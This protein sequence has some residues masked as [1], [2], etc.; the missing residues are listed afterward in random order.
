MSVKVAKTAGFCYGVRRAVDEV[1]K[2]VE[3]GEKIGVLGELIHNQ[4]VIDDLKSR[5]VKIYDDILDA[6]EDRTLIIRTHGVKKEVIDALCKK[7]ITIVDLTCPFV[8]KIHKIVKEN[9]ENGAQIVI[10][11]DKNHPEVIG[12]NGWCDDTAFITYDESCDFTP[13][14]DKNT[15]CVVAQTTINKEIFSKI[16]QNIKNTCKSVVVFDTICN[17]TK[18]RQT[19]A[20]SLS[21][22]SDV[23]F[24]I[25]G[26]KSSNTA[27]LFDIAK[28]NCPQAYFI[29]TKSD[30][31]SGLELKNKK[32]GIT[33]GAS[34]PGRIIE[35]VL[36][37]MDEK[38]T[39]EESFAE[40]FAQS[41]SKTLNNGDIVDAT[42]VE[43]RNNEVIV[44]LGG[45]KYNGQLAADQ[46]SDDPYA[47][48]TDL[49]KPGDVIK[50]YV[51]GVNDA[52]G[53][54][55]LSRKKLVAMESWNKMK[56]AFENKEI[57]NGKIIRS[58]KGGVIALVNQTQVFVPARHAALRFVQDLDSLVNTEVRLRLI[59]MDERKKRFVGSVRSV[60]EEEKKAVEDAFWASAEVGK[61]YTGAV[62]SLTSFGAF[63]DLGGVDG[64]VHISELSWNKIKH[65]SEVVKE[66]DV[67]T[68]YIKDL[69]PE[70]KK[71]SLGYKKAEDNP[72]V[73]AKSKYNV[74]DVVKCKVVRIMPFGA[75]CELMPNV[76]GLI[77]ISQIAD[78]RIGKPEDVLTIGDEV[79]AKILAIDWDTNKIS[80]SI[81]A[82]IEPP[83]EEA[84][85]EAADAP[86]EVQ[87]APVD[88]EVPVDIE[89]YIAENPAEE[90]EPVAE[91]AEENKDSAQAEE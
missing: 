44:D 6:E 38:M 78:R 63:V 8:G 45:F 4:Y 43:I 28:A 85:S 74:G 55:V 84:K 88:E 36:T 14:S 17:A 71:I 21:A 48:V 16:V 25:G 52:E 26:R 49:V 67:V 86:E 12:I 77:H 72:W 37:T 22:Q 10:I 53:K 50:V 24:V 47:K 41:E 56:E 60:L 90:E 76:D 34:T 30:I 19:E 61:E 33:A 9:Y 79:E 3:S 11:G 35:E 7:N 80:L 64:L 29:E 58:V 81:R 82:L 66:G 70:T 15:V 13:I 23:M 89:K 2:R 32:I 57:L 68:V 31:P 20:A 59:D 46:L 1:Y 75:F 40:L 27:K 83:A 51:V 5:G 18:D 39:N 54:V 73:I 62:K 91:V 69:N 87:E 42:V 65:P